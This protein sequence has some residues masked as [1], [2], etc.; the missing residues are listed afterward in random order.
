M[1]STRAYSR[2]TAPKD[3]NLDALV[4]RKGKDLDGQVVPVCPAARDGPKIGREEGAWAGAAQEADA[5]MVAAPHRG[6][7]ETA[8]K[9]IAGPFD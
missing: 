8:K 9:A 7:V 4:A 5:R 1:A 3:S 6:C 2:S